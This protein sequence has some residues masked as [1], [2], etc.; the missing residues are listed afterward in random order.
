VAP[1]PQYAR[2]EEPLSFSGFA[3]KYKYLEPGESEETEQ[4][5]GNGYLVVEG[6]VY[7]VLC[8]WLTDC[9]QEEFTPSGPVAPS[10]CS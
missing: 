2:S 10:L 5:E 3:E 7:A 9:R 6:G 4:N 1:Y 8:E